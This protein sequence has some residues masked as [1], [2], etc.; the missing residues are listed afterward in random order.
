LR[1]EEESILFSSEVSKGD[2]DITLTIEW[3]RLGSDPE[4]MRYEKAKRLT[5]ADR[6]KGVHRLSATH[7]VHPVTQCMFRIT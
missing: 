6:I 3:T 5:R 7:S 4:I 2:N 1:S